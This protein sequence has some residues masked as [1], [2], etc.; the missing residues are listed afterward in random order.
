MWD[1]YYITR[2]RLKSRPEDL[3][4]EFRG[5]VWARAINV[6]IGVEMEFKAMRQDE[7]SSPNTAQ[8]CPKS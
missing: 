1:V 4:L 6:V 2:V 8:A 7:T 5:K 3:N